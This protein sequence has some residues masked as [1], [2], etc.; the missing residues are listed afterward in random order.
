MAGQVQ[1]ETPSQLDF[2][3]LIGMESA[4][5]MRALTLPLH[6]PPPSFRS[7]GDP[8][9]HPW[10]RQAHRHPHRAQHRLEAVRVHLLLPHLCAAAPHSTARTRL[11]T[12][13]PLTQRDTPTLAASTADSAPPS[14]SLLSRLLREGAPGGV[15]RGPQRPQ[16]ARLTFPSDGQILDSAW[17]SGD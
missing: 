9:H 13:L 5:T 3:S 15:R 2:T 4:H 7:A 17:R 6:P 12:H 16:G 10:H 11:T 1:G 8:D 14:S